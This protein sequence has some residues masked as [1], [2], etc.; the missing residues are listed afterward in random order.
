MNDIIIIIRSPTDCVLYNFLQYGCHGTTLTKNHMMLKKCQ[1]KLMLE[2]LKLHLKQ[3]K[4]FIN[5]FINKLT[6]LNATTKRN[7]I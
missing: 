4:C 7:I 1:Q 5:H 2:N 6:K 3:T